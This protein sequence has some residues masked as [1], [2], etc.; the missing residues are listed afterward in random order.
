M[1]ILL[2]MSR[3][4]I[5]ILKKEPFQVM[6]TGEKKFEYRN[7]TQYWRNRLYKKDGSVKPFKYVEFSNG[8]QKNRPQFLV[9]F[10]GVEIID[11]VHEKYSSGF[12]VDYPFQKEGYL[13]IILGKVIREEDDK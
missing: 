2:I 5:M 4:L 1:M 7:N 12:E 9:E 3:N 11:E 13:K 10:L 8:Y 6:S